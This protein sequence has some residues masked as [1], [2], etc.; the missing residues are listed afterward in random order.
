MI[1]LVVLADGATATV[2]ATRRAS[3]PPGRAQ[4]GRTDR[5][6]QR[7]AHVPDFPDLAGFLATGEPPRR[8]DPDA[9]GAAVARSDGLEVRF[10]RVPVRRCATR[11][12]PPARVCQQCYSVD[13]MAPVALADI[14]RTVATFT[15]DR[16]AYTPN[17]PMMAAV[18]DFDGGGRFH[19]EL[20]D[21][22][23]RRSPS[24]SGSR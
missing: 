18:V 10:R 24:A 9:R 13:E 7:L 20:T 5:R 11:H 21:S 23:L 8:P 15:V 2:C 12:L 16:L 6:R 3:R 1:V 14:P 4:R 19:C 22:R 17:P